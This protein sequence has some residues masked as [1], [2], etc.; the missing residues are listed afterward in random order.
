MKKVLGNLVKPEYTAARV[1]KL[2]S[3]L[4]GRE[5]WGCC[6]GVPALFSPKLIPCLH[7]RLANGL[8]G[9]RQE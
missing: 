1:S 7:L 3:M 6:E 9:A 8:S 4:N 5:Q 2:D